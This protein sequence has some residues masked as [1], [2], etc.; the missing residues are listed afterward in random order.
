MAEK[1]ITVFHS[2]LLLVNIITRN[3]CLDI[4]LPVRESISVVSRDIIIILYDV[5][6]FAQNDEVCHAGCWLVMRTR[7]PIKSHI[8]SC[9]DTR[10]AQK[11]IEEVAGI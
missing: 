4:D 3:A 6:L 10:A 2:N 11:R 7:P 5:Y 1:C 8:K 9:H